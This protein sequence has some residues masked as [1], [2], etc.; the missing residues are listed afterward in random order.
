MRIFLYN[1]GMSKEEKIAELEAENAKL[2]AENNHLSGENAKLKILNNWYLEQYRLAQHRRF[3]SKSEQTELPEQ[4]G[5]FNEA[6]ALADKEPETVGPYHR[7]KRKGKRDEFYDGLPTEQI[8][9]ELPQSERVCPDCGGPLHACGHEVLRREVE[10][11]PAQIR[12]VEHVQTVYACRC[13]E[14]S[15]DADSQPM[16]K[17]PVPAPVIAGSGMASPSLVAFI[18]CNKYVLALPIYRQEQEL[19]RIGVHISRQTMANWIIFTATKWLLPIYNLFKEALLRCGILH[20]DETTLQVI[21]EDGRKASQ[22]SYM[23]EYHTGRD[24]EKQIAL[25]EYRETRDG[26]HPRKFLKGFQG[27]LHVDGYAGYKKLE[28]QGVTIVECWAHARRKFHDAMKALSKSERV[29]TVANIGLEYCDKLFAL[30]RKFDEEKLT[31]EA[32]LERR[33]LE[34]KPVAEAFFAWAQSKLPGAMPKSKL[35]V[36]LAYAV[37]QRHWLMNFLLDGRLELSNNRAERTIRPFT[38]GRKNW[39]FAYCARGAKASAIVYSIIETAQANGLVPFM[40]LNYLFQTLPN[41]P[42][43]QFS[44]CL[45]WNPSVRKICEIPPLQ[46]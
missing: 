1:K 4:L 43:D 38:V 9:H 40:Y 27:F 22:K 41:I 2:K 18:M 46:S 24:A 5:L 28:E 36:A 37:N 20:A 33:I 42:Q 12:A 30:E 6:E 34:S 45:P 13:C 11:I 19:G 32:R 15:S 25:F 17:A 21:R 14:Q 29:D 7:K 26:E 44:E 8:I 31:P 16:V 10:V 39:L 23:W 3:G 35:G